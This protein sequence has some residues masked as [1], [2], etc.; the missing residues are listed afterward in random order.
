MERRFGT[1]ADTM[2]LELRDLSEHHVCAMGA[3]TQTLAHYGPQENYTIHVVDSAPSMLAQFED[4]SQVEKY[5]ISEEE[6][7][8]RDDTFRKFKA[9]MQKKDPN[10]MKKSGNKIPDDFQ[11]EEA[12]AVAAG[13]RC[14]L[15]I[16]SRRGEVKYVGLVPE[17][18]PGYWV[19]VQL[20][21]PTGDSDGKV[22]GKSYF[23]VPAAKFGVFI[24]PKDALYG[25][26][27]PV[28]DFDEDEDEI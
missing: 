24:R 27:P 4:V 1:S 16:G 7:A 25:D 6:Y 22:K 10:F 14:Q 20:D 8:K 19:G 15:V 17:L 13:Q 2:S 23:T 26:F 18:A 28:D 11:K 5:Q 21:E 3:D 9:D 12:S